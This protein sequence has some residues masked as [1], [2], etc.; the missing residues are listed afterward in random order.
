MPTSWRSTTRRSTGHGWTW[1]R[2]NWVFFPA[3]VWT[4]GSTTWRI[5][6][7]R[8]PRGSGSGAWLAGG[9]GVLLG[10]ALLQQVAPALRV[11]D[12]VAE[13]P[14]QGLHG[15]A[16]RQGDGFDVLA[17]QIGEPSAAVDINIIQQPALGKASAQRTQKLRQGRPQAGDLLGCPP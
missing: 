10:H 8:W 15:A 11:P 12:V 17:I 5:G 4:G 14:L 3:S 1:R 2:L 16:G 13:K 6:D 7:V 9:R